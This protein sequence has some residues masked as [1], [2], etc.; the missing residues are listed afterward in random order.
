MAQVVLV[1]EGTEATLKPLPNTFDKLKAKA[2]SEFSLT[3]L[4]IL[5]GDVKITSTNDLLV[6]YLNSQE[7]RVVFRVEEDVK[8]IS[9]VDSSMQAL[10]NM[11]TGSASTPPQ[12][13]RIT[14]GALSL[15]DLKTVLN[16]VNELSSQQI[17]EI[18]RKLQED[19]LAFY[20]VDDTKYKQV[21]MEQMQ[22]QAM[23]QISNVQQTLSKYNVTPEVFE[24]SMQIHQN[25]IGDLMGAALGELGA[26]GPVSEALT[27]EKF[28]EIL[29]YSSQFTLDY[30]VAHPSI[31]RLDFGILK[32]RE[33]DEVFSRF[34]FTEME[35]TAGFKVH[36]FD[37]SAEWDDIKQKLG[38]LQER[39]MTLEGAY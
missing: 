25:D 15:P 13:F 16:E 1:F 33:A 20:N 14:N 27:K 29:E 18:S 30:L 39:I 26:G 6:A 31:S 3:E 34:G 32:L 23:L 19:R 24:K 28:R 2:R 36:D 17:S 21:A 4:F 35:I 10:F 22:F 37:S 7:D 38:K 9:I 5:V 11:M 12:G 8:P